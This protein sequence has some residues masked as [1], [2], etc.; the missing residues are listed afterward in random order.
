MKVFT[1]ILALFAV[2]LAACNREP[3]SVPASP[4]TLATPAATA[5]PTDATPLQ[6]DQEVE[7]QLVSVTP[8]SMVDCNGIEATVHWDVRTSYPDIAEVELWVGP[9]SSPTL[10]AAGGAYGEN[11]TGPWVRP[12]EIIRLRNKSTGEELGRAT[13]TGPSCG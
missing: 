8:S 5:A 2:S 13:V 7:Q 3:E 12:G 6:T 9:D 11:K 1:L 4:S 10:F